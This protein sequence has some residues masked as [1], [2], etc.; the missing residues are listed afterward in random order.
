[1]LQVTNDVRS[2]VRTNHI[3]LCWN[4]R[5]GVTLMRQFAIEFGVHSSL[6]IYS[7][8][9][10]SNRKTI[11][12][13][14][15]L[16]RGNVMRIEVSVLLGCQSVIIPKE[17]KPCQF[18]LDVCLVSVTSYLIMIM[19]VNESNKDCEGKTRG[20]EPRIQSVTKYGFINNM[21]GIGIQSGLAAR[22]R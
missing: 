1:M 12:I 11:I 2:H 19:T 10:N 4:M 6:S 7:K 16:T 15:L 14:L 17:Q 9:S 22:I 3:S 13:L 20:S 5:Q 18:M 21:D 8:N